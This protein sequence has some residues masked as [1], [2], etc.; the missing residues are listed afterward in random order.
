MKVAVV[1][2]GSRGIGEATVIALQKKGYQVAT[3]SRSQSGLEKSSADFKQVC[4]VSK[5]PQVKSFISSVVKK[6]N[7]IDVLVNNAGKGGADSMEDPS[8]EAWDEM[9][10]INLNGTFYFCKAVLP[11]MSESG[12]IVNISSVLGL[13]GVPGAMGYCAAKHGVIGLTKA[14]A[15]TV[16]PRKITVNAICPG[17]VRTEMAAQR[18][19]ELGWSEA[20]L[21]KTVALGRFIEPEEVAAMV[22]YLVSPEASGVTGEAL[23]IDGG[24]I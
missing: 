3:C 13:K 20:F 11:H 8:D 4:D 19:Q 1:T 15:Y 9:I 6:W 10:D 7:A 2:G 24:A 14:L 23:V 21:K 12:R 17:W 18:F 5:S 22:T 16:A